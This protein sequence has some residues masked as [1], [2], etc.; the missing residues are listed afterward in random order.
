MDESKNIILRVNYKLNDKKGMRKL[1]M[2]LSLL[3]LTVIVS[4]QSIQINGVRKKEF[5]G[6]SA[7]MDG[8]QSSGYYTYY[9]NEK[10]KKGM[11]E[12]TLEIYDLDLNLIKKTPIQLTKN[13]IMNGGEYNGKDFL[14]LFTD[15]T[16][17]T[18][19]FITLDSKGVIIKKISKKAKK[20]M[21]AMGTAIYP[22]K[23]GNGFYVT[24]MVKVKKWGYS[25]EKYDR[26]LTL[27][28]DK[29]VVKS[30]G[31]IGVAAAEGAE[32]KFV[33][34]S[35]ERPTLMSKKVTG[36]IVAYNSE[37]GD[38]LF[39]QNLYNG[40]IT[41]I[42][43]SFLI[44][45][46]GNIVMAG[47][48]FIGQKW[49]AKNS[50]GIY[51]TKLNPDGEV[52]FE[53]SIDWDNGIQDALKA[54]SRKFSIGSKPKVLFHDITEDKDGNY[55]IISETFRKTV[56]AG[57]VLGALSGSGQDAPVGFTVMDYIIFNYDSE[58]NPIDIN[59]IEKP[60]KSILVASS[61]ASAG[62]VSTAYYM[63]SLGLFT[64]E[65]IAESES[66]EKAV[67]YTNFEKPKGVGTG[68]PYIGVSSIKIGEESRT[69]KIPLTRKQVSWKTAGTKTGALKSKKGKMCVYYYNK[70]EKTINL[71]IED[72]SID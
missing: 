71:S 3:L 14:F 45:K 69:K 26:N 63:K 62:G 51:F 8:N 66:G 5:K 49:H 48:Y 44:D 52:L 53:N 22:S 20:I 9:V 59:K 13:S 4:A 68:K 17:K 35:T 41:R 70:K 46:E 54:T 42:P 50:D 30:K 31:M 2:S 57:T 10:V 72:L 58:G 27:L 11:I 47:M 67:V 24:K 18:N 6:V 32:G 34:I 21:T 19:T 28:W 40:K 36:K 43:S 55:Q 39:E 61:I 33:V 65:F 7:I 60:Y 25:V 64:H 38:K 29:I 23:D 37:S 12:F 1:F 16:K 56:K 15:L